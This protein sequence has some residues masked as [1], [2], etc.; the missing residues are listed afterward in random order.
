MVRHSAIPGSFSTSR[1]FPRLGWNLATSQVRVHV[2][3]CMLT[4]C[5]RGRSAVVVSHVF[6]CTTADVELTCAHCTVNASV[7][8]SVYQRI[9]AS[10]CLTGSTPLYQ[11]TVAA[12][13]TGIVGSGNQYLCLPPF[14]QLLNFTLTNYSS[15]EITR[16]RYGLATSGIVG[17]RDRDARRPICTIC[18][19]PNSRPGAVIIPARTSCPSGYTMDYT[20]S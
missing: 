16:V 13:P 18:Q 12:S 3:V 20:G 15:A 5:I 4:S 9:G 19:R 7:G 2:D 1:S 14:T 17:I 8:G 6:F 11:G 10:T